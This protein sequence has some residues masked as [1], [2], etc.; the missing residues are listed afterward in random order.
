[1]E[2]FIRKSTL[3]M[4][5]AGTIFFLSCGDDTEDGNPVDP[6][7]AVIS[8]GPFNFIVDGVADNIPE[9]AIT[10]DQPGTEL[11]SVG[12]I[13]TNEA[14]DI[15]GLPPSFTAPDFDGAGGGTC[16]V[17]YINYAAGLEGLTGPDAEGNPTSNTDDLDGE[18]ALSNAIAV[19]RLDAPTLSGGPFEFIVGDSIPD[20]LAEDDIMVTGGFALEGQ[21][22]WVVTNEE[23]DILGLPDSFTAVDFNGAGEGTCFVWYITYAEGITG[24][25]G[26]GMDGIPT[27]NVDDLDGIFEISE[28]SIEVIRK[29]APAIVGDDLNFIVDGVEDKIPADAIEIADMGTDLGNTAWVVTDLDGNILGLP[30]ESFTQPEFDE[31][32][33]G[34]CLVWY[35]NYTEG[36][37]GLTGPDMNGMATS[38]LDDLDGEFALSNSIA[39]NRLNA[40][41]LTGG[42]FTFTAGDGMADN[43]AEDGITVSD[44]GYA[45][46]GQSGWVIT[47]EAGNILGLPPTFSAPDFDGAGVGVCLVWY[48]TY[49]EG[50]EGLDG[51][52]GDGNPTAN[53]N[54]LDGVFE[55]SN[56]IEVNRVAADM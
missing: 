47:D 35:L 30:P 17:W 45:L 40:P 16:L 31:A 34:T 53:T 50:L 27:S 8:G 12:W 42:P 9:G 3:I 37:E 55:L 24:L 23:G 21:S 20:N 22:K 18:F 29:A 38:S 49:A 14:G 1:M 48:I 13:V 41:T 56:S 19:N 7:A 33:A 44:D 39:V 2:N 25:T 4:A 10:V 51:P 32:G 15:L 5:L 52:D 43:I 54:D 28:E 6:T 36:L 26:P 46:E 11:D